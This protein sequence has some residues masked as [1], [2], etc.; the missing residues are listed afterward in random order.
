MTSAVRLLAA[1]AFVALA[2]GAIA[3]LPPLSEDAKQKAAEAAAKADHAGKVAG[4]ELCRAQDKVAAA[5]RQ[6][7]QAE[8]KK[9]NPPG[10]VPPCADPGVQPSPVAAGLEQAGAHSN[11]AAGSSASVK[12][13]PPT[14]SPAV[15]EQPTPVQKKP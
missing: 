1:T 10:E 7:L 11:P 14:N 15:A 2:Q 8:G 4:F 5:Y 3:K 6:K 9:P 12:R 13:P